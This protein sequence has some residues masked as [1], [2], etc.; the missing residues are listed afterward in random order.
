MEDPASGESHFLLACPRLPGTAFIIPQ[1]IPVS[2]IVIG[3]Y[4]LIVI[5]SLAMGNVDSIVLN[6]VHKPVFLVNPSAE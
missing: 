1:K 6:A 2:M 4:L 5:M 3:R